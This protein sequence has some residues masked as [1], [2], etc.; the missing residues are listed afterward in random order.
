MTAPY[1]DLAR[2]P[3]AHPRRGQGPLAGVRVVDFCWVGVGACATRALSDFG[4]E[5]IKIEDRARVDMTRRLPLYKGEP[6]R[7]YGQEDVNPDVNR[8]G[9]FNNYNRNKLSCTINM[10]SPKGR[11]LI[12]QLIAKSS[13]VTENFAPGVMERWGLV[14]ERL[15]ELCPDVIFGRMSGYGHSGPDADFRSYG[16]IIQAVSGLSFISGLPNMPPS[17]W[18]LSYMDNQAA[19]FNSAAL[20]MAILNRTVTG[21][22]C[23][24]DVS[25]VEVGIKLLGP[26]LLEVA[27]NGRRTRDEVFPIGNRLEYPTAAPHGVYPLAEEDRWVAIAVLEEAEWDALKTLM[28][29][30]AW[31]EAGHF[32]D[33]AQRRLHQ[34]ELDRLV[35]EWTRGLDH[36]TVTDRL[37][38]AGVRGALVQTAE[39]LNEFDPQ[40]AERGLFF[41]L[42]HPVIGPARFEGS[43]MLFS[44]MEQVN[45]R[46]GPLLGEDTRFVLTDILGLEDDA[47]TALEEEGVI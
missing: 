12:D 23:E 2:S 11:A 18:G 27:A 31:A 14:Y 25:A 30:P 5:V 32:H 37:Q 29:R 17:G 9:V 7:A 3:R 10:R 41:E 45:W 16:P 43:P 38:A 24:I 42:D 22:G 44:D 6:A 47:V 19:Y 36:R 46:S 35:A 13:V 33:M 1:P 8:G 21:R 28:G 20:M 4:A 34:D 39:D 26:M 40:L 15:C